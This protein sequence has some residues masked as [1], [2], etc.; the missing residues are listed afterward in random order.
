MVSVLAFSDSPP[1][2]SPRCWEAAW[3]QR[4][5]QALVSHMWQVALG[6][7]TLVW[8]VCCALPVSSL[9]VSISVCLYLPLSNYNC[10]SISMSLFSI[11]SSLYMYLPLCVYIYFLMCIYIIYLRTYLLTCLFCLHYANSSLKVEHVD[12]K[13]LPLG[14]SDSPGGGETLRRSSMVPIPAR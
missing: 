2:R 8:K 1:S 13:N 6:A 3:G 5:G 14:R 7:D 12:M 10:L 4:R 9:S 11:S